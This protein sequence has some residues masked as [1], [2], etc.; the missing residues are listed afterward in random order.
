M[1]MALVGADRP[2]SE[3]QLVVGRQVI[4]TGVRAWRAQNLSVNL[5]HDVDY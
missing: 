5:R 1:L 3:A 2:H 4:G